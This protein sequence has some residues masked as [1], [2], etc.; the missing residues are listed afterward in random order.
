MTPG[1]PSKYI[2]GKGF[3]TFVPYC[4]I[5]SITTLLQRTAYPRPIFA[6]VC[7]NCMTKSADLQHTQ[8]GWTLV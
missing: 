7:Q 8:A 4:T 3:M 5:T 1:M 6:S 2:T